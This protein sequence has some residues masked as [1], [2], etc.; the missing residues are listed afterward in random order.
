MTDIQFKK[1]EDD[2]EFNHLAD[3]KEPSDADYLYKKIDL[4]YEDDCYDYDSDEV[5]EDY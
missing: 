4:Y 1:L 5:D 3:F 2:F